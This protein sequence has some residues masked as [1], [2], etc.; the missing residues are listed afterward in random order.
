M[1][2]ILVPTEFSAH[3]NQV[4]LYALS[5]AKQQKAKITLLHAYHIPINPNSSME[6]IGIDTLTLLQEFVDTHTKELSI[7]RSKLHRRNGSCCRRHLQNDTRRRD[8]LNCNG[9]E[10]KNQCL[11]SLLWECFSG[12][13]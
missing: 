4:F 10:R 11:G 6:D 9:H 13:C 8:R 2:N 12:C 3:A 5:L 7:R 1:K